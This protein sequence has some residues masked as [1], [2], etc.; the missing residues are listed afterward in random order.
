M[1]IKVPFFCDVTL[2]RH[3]P[4]LRPWTWRKYVSLKPY[5]L[6]IYQPIRHMP[7]D[8]EW[9]TIFQYFIA[10]RHKCREDWPSKSSERAYNI[11]LDA[12]LL[13][14]PLI[15]MT[16]A[17]SLIVSKLWKGLQREIRHNSSCRR[18]RE[19]RPY[20]LFGIKPFNA[21]HGLFW[22][23]AL[24]LLPWILNFRR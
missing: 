11:F 16:L 20:Y 17:Y 24:S 12:M 13:L 6:S 23:E 22:L 19:Y 5:L 18:Q 4:V 21:T 3:V 1:C 10:G 15:I 7:E 2:Y 9:S 8:F 14:V